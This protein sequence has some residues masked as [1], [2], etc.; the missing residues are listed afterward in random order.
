[1]KKAI[2]TQLMARPCASRDFHAARIAR[3]PESPR[4]AFAGIARNSL[5]RSTRATRRTCCW[6]WERLR[7]PNALPFHNRV[8]SVGGDILQLLHLATGPADLHGIDLRSGTEAKMLTKIVLR[9]ITATATDFAELLDAASANRDAG[10]N[11]G[12]ITL[13]ADEFE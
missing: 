3:G 7:F 4:G 9:K 10:A 13:C 1:M 8:D 11:C 6:R 2:R 12:A 5:T